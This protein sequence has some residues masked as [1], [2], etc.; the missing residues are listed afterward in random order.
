M[1]S[2]GRM[3]LIECQPSFL[4]G[5]HY[6]NFAHLWQLSPL[7]KCEIILIYSHHL[8]I[9]KTFLSLIHPPCH[10]SYHSHYVCSD[11]NHNEE[12]FHRHHFLSRWFFSCV[13]CG[14]RVRALEDHDKIMTDLIDMNPI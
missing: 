4:L 13:E 12:F 6:V 3:S 9:F 8:N 11:C 1:S 7:A 5:N 10:L 2:G 14:D